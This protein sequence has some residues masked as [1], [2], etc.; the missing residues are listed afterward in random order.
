MHAN[1]NEPQ[2]VRP[3]GISLAAAIFA[4]H[5]S[6]SHPLLGQLLLVAFGFLTQTCRIL[7][8]R[9]TS[10]AFSR[11]SFLRKSAVVRDKEEKT[12]PN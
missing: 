10:G 12:K 3:R 1:V 8:A 11:V 5:P 2:Q 4:G 9:Q 6:I 7:A